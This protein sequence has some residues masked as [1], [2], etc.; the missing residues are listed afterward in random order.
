[1]RHPFAAVLLV[2]ASAVIAGARMRRSASGPRMLRS[3]P[4]PGS[5][6]A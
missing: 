6:L 5:A 4:W 3:T 1:M 2:A